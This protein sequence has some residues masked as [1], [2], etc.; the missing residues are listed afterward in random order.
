MALVLKDRVKERSDTSGTGPL[1]L[2]GAH[3]GYRT[4]ASCVPTGAAVYYTVHNTVAGYEGEWEVGHGVFTLA[5]NTI[6]RVS[7][8]ASSNSDA[9]V[10]FSAGA[11]EVF[12]TY[13]AGQA[14]VQS[15]DKYSDPRTVAASTVLGAAQDFGSVVIANA[16]FS[17][18]ALPDVRVDLA[19]DT[20]SYDHGSV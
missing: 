8:H 18:E 10:D 3:T 14:V 1:L 9:L 16:H 19:L 20:G 15:L 4:F 11:K 6:T 7:V 5:G 2:A 13:P 12:I 17:N